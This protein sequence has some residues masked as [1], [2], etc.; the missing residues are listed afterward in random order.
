[1]KKLFSAFLTV[2]FLAIF[3]EIAFAGDVWVKP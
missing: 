3:A 2:T 1:M